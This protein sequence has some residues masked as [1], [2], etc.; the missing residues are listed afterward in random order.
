[1][2]DL[3]IGEEHESVANVTIDGVAYSLV[4]KAFRQA[5][6]GQSERADTA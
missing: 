5:R 6:R 1:M 3:K 4:S 2:M